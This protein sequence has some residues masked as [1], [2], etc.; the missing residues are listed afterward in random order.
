MFNE[1]KTH[2]GLMAL[3][4]CMSL[5]PALAAET[6]FFIRSAINSTARLRMNWLG[7]KSG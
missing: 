2:V 3:I 5:T 4:G 7:S 1:S 6:L